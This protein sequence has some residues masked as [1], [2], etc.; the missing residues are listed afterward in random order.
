MYEGAG[1]GREADVRSTGE[2]Q[3]PRRSIKVEFRKFFHPLHLSHSDNLRRFWT[4][5]SV[6][7]LHILLIIDGLKR[8][9]SCFKVHRA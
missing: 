4:S 9:T 6:S 5:R 3:L 8:E 2:P 1:G 7:S